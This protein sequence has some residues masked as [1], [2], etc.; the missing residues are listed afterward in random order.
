MA[1]NLINISILKHIYSYISNAENNTNKARVQILEPLTTIV[2]L[3]IISFKPIG[4]KIA[5][6]NNKLYIQSPN[7]AQGVLRWTYGNNREEVHHLLKPIFR[8]LQIYDPKKSATYRCIFTFSIMGLRLLKKS[9]N[10]SSSTLCHAL[11][12]YI[13]IIDNC[14]NNDGITLDNCTNMSSIKNC[15]NLSHNTKINLEKLF[16]NIWTLDEIKLISNM[17]NLANTK[18]S[19]KKKLYKRD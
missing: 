13:N 9:Y 1:S 18:T 19:Q 17:L 5:I 16:E 3:A 15:L 6:S 14:I 2:K 11:D 4:T 10:N 8:A 12:L 7:I